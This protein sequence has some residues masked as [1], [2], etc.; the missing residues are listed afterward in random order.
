[1]P[2]DFASR[3][4]RLLPPPPTCS[5]V[6]ASRGLVAVSDQQIRRLPCLRKHLESPP[7]DQPP[8]SHRRFS[9]REDED[10]LLVEL[11]PHSPSLTMPCYTGLLPRENQPRP[12]VGLPSPASARPSLKPASYTTPRSARSGPSFVLFNYARP[13]ASKFRHSPLAEEDKMEEVF[14]ACCVTNEHPRVPIPLYQ[15]SA[16]RINLSDESGSEGDKKQ[17]THRVIHAKHGKNRASPYSPSPK[18]NEKWASGHAR[19]Q[20]FVRMVDLFDSRGKR[21]ET[22]VSARQEIHEM[23]AMIEADGGAPESD[24]HFYASQLFRDQTN[25]DVFSAFKDHEPSARLR[26]INRTWEFNN[27]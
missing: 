3:P 18:N 5:E 21:D 24:V 8:P 25:R 4:R 6:L 9:F 15:V 20:A 27:K 10:E 22:K 12:G 13:Q 11:S 17:V 14:D 2:P 16:S 7:P 19:N 1:M 26:W 23:M